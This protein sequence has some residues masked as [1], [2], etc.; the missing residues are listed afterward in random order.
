MKSYK[1]KRHFALA[2]PA[3]PAVI[4]KHWHL[5]ATDIFALSF[6]VCGCS[7]LSIRQWAPV[8]A[9]LKS[10][11]FLLKVDLL[12][13]LAW[14][15][16]FLIIYILFLVYNIISRISNFALFKLL[17]VKL[18]HKF[19]AYVCCFC[20]VCPMFHGFSHA[21]TKTVQCSPS[22]WVLNRGVPCRD[23]ATLALIDPGYIF[24][25]SRPDETALEELK[26]PAGQ[27]L[28][29]FGVDSKA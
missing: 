13:I 10:T 17:P 14:F 24:S 18:L 15:G 12:Q 3:S 16:C 4:S 22:D 7:V 25:R 27:D 29:S 23:C 9:P 28:F 8:M 11:Q 1:I 26:G 6:S 2:V 20:D 21:H 19:Y 5:S